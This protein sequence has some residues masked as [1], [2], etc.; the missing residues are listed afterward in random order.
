MRS[1]LAVLLSLFWCCGAQAQT[2][3]DNLLQNSGMNIAVLNGTASVAMVNPPGG[4]ITVDRWR[5]DMIG[6]TITGTIQKSSD[7]PSGLRASLE[8]LISTPQPTLGPNEL[9]SVF[10][11]LEGSKMAPLGWGTPAAR[12]MSCGWFTEA[13]KTGQHGG[14]VKNFDGSRTWAFAYPIPTAGAWTFNTT[15]ITGD[16]SAGWANADG[17]IWG[18]FLLNVA[19]GPSFQIT[20]GAWHVGNAA[21]ATG[22]VNNAHDVG[23]YIRFTGVMCFAGD[24]PPTE[25]QAASLLRPDFEEL[26]L[27]ERYYRK[28]FQPPLNGG[29]FTGGT[30]CVHLRMPLDPPMAKKPTTI[31]VVG[32]MPVSDGP[33]VDT[34]VASGTSSSAPWGDSSTASTLDINV[35]TTNHTLTAGRPCY[36]YTDGGASYVEMYA[37][38]GP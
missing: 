30:Q 32:S 2:A 20:P 23:D 26:R 31:R 17:S 34:L 4:G 8:V 5:F 11:A 12:N 9:V 14:V 1:S 21:N 36:V 24:T 38:P 28:R 16:T 35:A 22:S 27:T 25:A 33:N 29:V 6:S 10:Q 15:T 37:E 7:A 13:S 3:A 18:Y 19:S